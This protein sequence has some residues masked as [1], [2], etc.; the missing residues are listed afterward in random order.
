[1][2]EAISKGKLM[3]Y[4][5]YPGHGHGVGGPDRLH[6]NKKIATYFMDNL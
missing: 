4:F 6:L 1:V 2:K 5:V 3:D